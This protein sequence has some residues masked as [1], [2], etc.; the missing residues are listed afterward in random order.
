MFGGND[1]QPTPPSAPI[2]QATT[3]MPTAA[4]S[5]PGTD[6]QK[7]AGQLEANQAKPGSLA[8]PSQDQEDSNKS[9]LGR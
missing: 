4:P 2:Q 5:Q 7:I 1:Q 8:T 6:P 9:L 3:P